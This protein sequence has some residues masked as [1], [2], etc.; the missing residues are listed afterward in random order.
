MMSKPASFQT[1]NRGLSGNALKIVAI[2]AMTI[3]HLAWVF[4]P[5]F[6][7]APTTII[8]H[9]IGRIT[10]PVMMFFVSE[11]YHY[12]HN[13]NKYLAR[14]LLFAAIS[15]IPYL[16]FSDFVIIPGIPTMNVIWPFA[17][18]VLA[19]M[20]DQGDIL[21]DIKRWQRTVLTWIPLALA[22]PS[23][24]SMPAAIAILLMGRQWGNLKRQMS[25][26]AILLAVYAVICGLLFDPI[27]GLIHIGI[28]IPIILL[29]FFYNGT[30]GIVGGKAMKWI[31]YIYYPSHPLI[32]GLIKIIYGDGFF[33]PLG[34]IGSA[35]ILASLASAIIIFFMENKKGR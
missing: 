19:L 14:L 4:Y 15:Q 23:D 25:D 16:M 9:V 24:W 34:L 30:R 17:M 6:D 11:G 31:F 28:I 8:M 21:P 5:G 18:G 27:Y 35:F 32:L 29:Y 33:K 10:A 7:M 12:T 26:M 2:I 22:F 20:I 13:R 1:V 3:D